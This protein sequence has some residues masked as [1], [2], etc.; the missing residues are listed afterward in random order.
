MN[1]SHHA[2]HAPFIF[3]P[4][5]AI[6]GPQYSLWIFSSEEGDKQ[7]LIFFVKNVSWSIPEPCTGYACPASWVFA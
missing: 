5:M 2:H 7:W 4:H 3:G 1:S 6:T